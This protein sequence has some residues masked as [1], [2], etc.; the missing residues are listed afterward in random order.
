MEDII[1]G[2]ESSREIEHILTVGE[3]V[4]RASTMSMAFTAGGYLNLGESDTGTAPVPSTLATELLGT[5]PATSS[6]QRQADDLLTHKRHR[7]AARLASRSFTSTNKLYRYKFVGILTGLYCLLEIIVA[8]HTDSLALLSDGFHNLGD[9]LAVWIA[10]WVESHKYSRADMEYTYGYKR[11]E[12]VG[13]LA[14]GWSLMALCLYILLESFSRLFDKTKVHSGPA[15]IATAAVGLVINLCGA[16][17]FQDVHVHGPG[18]HCPSHGISDEQPTQFDSRSQSDG[19]CLAE[20]HGHS[21][22]QGSESHGHDAS[23]HGHAHA[24]HGHAHAS[25]GHSHG[26]SHRAYGVLEVSGDYSPLK[27]QSRSC[28]TS[29]KQKQPDA[30][31]ADHKNQ[32]TTH[33]D[34]NMRAVYLH[35]LGDA[36]SSLLVLVE[37]LI[38]LTSSGNWLLYLDPVMSWLVVGVIVSTTIPVLRECS[39]LVLQTTPRDI[40][41][42]ELYEALCSIPG[43]EG[44]HDLHVWTVTPGLTVSSL[45]YLTA[46]GADTAKAMERIRAALHSRGVHSSTIQP[47]CLPPHQL[48]SRKSMGICGENCLPACDKDWCCADVDDL[49]MSSRRAYSPAASS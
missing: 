34:L 4:Q 28:D 40:D 46:E 44:V 27:A 43:V 13:G 6:E 38:L 14:N 45:H 10:F 31:C 5:T 11:V 20:A 33:G 36:L 47:E 39:L 16:F 24:S 17:L 35:Y 18:A 1:D 8:V 19:A 21:H 7:H 37:G 15:F 42:G 41:L 26:H 29:R 2:V 48:K 49:W 9:V 23:H 3:E 12:V 30:R 32:H 22:G 25:H